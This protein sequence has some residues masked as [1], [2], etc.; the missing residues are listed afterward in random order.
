MRTFE[1]IVE[2]RTDKELV[3]IFLNPHI[4]KNEFVKVVTAEL[5]KRKIHNDSI[6]PIKEDAEK[7][8]D[9]KL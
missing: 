9:K 4:Y 7:D 2:K 6:N 5:D 1:E 8:S 3:D